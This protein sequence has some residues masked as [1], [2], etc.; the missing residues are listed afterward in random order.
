M[1]KS[2]PFNNLLKSLLS[3]KII[4]IILVLAFVFFPA[5]CCFAEE[6]VT[7]VRTIMYILGT[8]FVV[9]LNTLVALTFLSP[10]LVIIYFFF[11]YPLLEKRRLKEYVEK[12]HLKYIEMITKLPDNL[13]I[14]FI[15]F[16]GLRQFKNVIIFHKEDISYM[17][18][19]LKFSFSTSMAKSG[20]CPLP[21]LIII[22]KR[23]NF[24]YFF[25]REPTFDNNIKYR[26]S[27]SG[28][29]HAYRATEEEYQR[30]LSFYQGYNLTIDEDP[31]FADKYIL[32]VDENDKEAVIE[33]FNKKTRSVFKE[34]SNKGHCYEGNGNLFVVC[35]NIDL[36]FKDKIKFMEDNINLYRKIFN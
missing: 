10:F 19:E 24:P 8:T 29:K 22:D 25:L 23:Q 16:K 9:L 6:E 26:C 13:D 36:C 30:R 33:F 27:Y 35:S 5:T 17:L 7:F 12:N 15:K 31:E 34:Y 20:S 18:M 2:I 1:I 11:I 21:L 32:D 28:S 4:E 3:N 14:N